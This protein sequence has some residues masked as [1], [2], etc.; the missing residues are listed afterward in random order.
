VNVLIVNAYSA[1]N[2][3]DGMIVSQMVRL[4]RARG[5]EVKVMSDDPRDGDRYDV[6]RLEPLAPIWPGENGGPSKPAIIA[7]M[8]GDLVRPGQRQAFRWADVCVSAGGGYLYDDG[9]RT[10]RLNAARRLLPLRA[11]RRLGV[12][13][14]LFSQ[15]IGPFRSALWRSIVGRELRHSRRVIV[16]EE[17]SL[18]VARGMGL[19]P[20]LCDDVAFAL[21]PGEPPAGAPE[22]RPGTIGVTAMSSLPGVDEAGHRRYLE[23][24]QAGLIEAVGAA[25][26]P[27]AVISQV[28]AHAGDDDVGV[29][30]ELC[31]RLVE[32]GLSAGFVDLGDAGDEEVSAFYGRL[33]LVVASRLHSGIL[34][35][36]AGTPIV[37]LSYL[38]KTDGVLARLGLDRWVLP[39]AGLR[40]DPLA[41]TLRAALADTAALR[42]EIQARLPELRASATRAVDLT[43]EVAK[44]SNLRA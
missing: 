12:P 44:R 15:S 40:A 39:A 33:D 6:E 16:R 37:A 25:G 21:E 14:V 24:L 32:A 41:A 42:H 13:V 20:E 27:V 43:L 23:E 29:G 4:F 38:P 34:A 7:R 28:S 35:L 26:R 30:T 3:G 36:C 17:L 9:S 18:A 1:R 11:A 19:S 8:G 22:V 31:R 10:A 2:R 5:C